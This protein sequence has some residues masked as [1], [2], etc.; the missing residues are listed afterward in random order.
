MSDDPLRDGPVM[1]GAPVIPA[2]D[3]DQ[4][5]RALS[6]LPHIEREALLLKSREGLGYAEIG[7]LL[8]LSPAQAEARAAAALAK[9]HRRLTRRRPWWRFW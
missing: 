9:L 6:R 4:V 8:G 5:E 2:L 1:P 7:A 3:P